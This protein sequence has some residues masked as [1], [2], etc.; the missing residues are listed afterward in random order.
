MKT[1][2]IDYLCNQN[3]NSCE[4]KLHMVSF[5]LICEDHIIH[6]KNTLKCFEKVTCKLIV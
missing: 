3:N 2:D 5:G 4:V 1:L 6:V